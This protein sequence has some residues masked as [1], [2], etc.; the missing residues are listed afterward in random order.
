MSLRSPSLRRTHRFSRRS[1]ARLLLAVGLA[2]GGAAVAHVNHRA[3]DALRHES[4]RGD[5]LLFIP[6]GKALRVGTMGYSELAADALWIRTV[7]MFGERWGSTPAEQWRDW[8]LGML[9]G[10]IHLDPQWRTPYFYGGMMLRV[11]EHA[12][13]SDKVFHAAIQALPDDP[14]FP[15]ALGMNAWLLRDDPVTAA[16]WLR[17]AAR[18][19]GAPPWYRAAAAGFLVEK[20]RRRTAIRFLQEERR[21]TSNPR[22]QKILDRK[23]RELYHDEFAERLHRARERFR[24]DRGRDIERVEELERPDRPLP[25]DPLG[26]RWIIGSDGRIRS[27]EREASLRERARRRERGWLRR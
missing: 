18:R 12:D 26:G 20:Q 14:F 9:Q 16:Y 15:F 25:E 8:M 17:V 21:Q 22:V 3:A 4:A 24:R 23:L 11:M 19:P 27:S 6:Q 7:L 5:D 1:L 13:G 2:V 10:I